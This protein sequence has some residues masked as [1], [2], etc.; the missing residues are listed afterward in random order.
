MIL[1]VRK[2]SASHVFSGVFF[3]GCISNGTQPKT[4]CYLHIPS[5]GAKRKK[6][7]KCIHSSRNFEYAILILNVS[8]LFVGQKRL[9]FQI[10]KLIQIKIK[11]A[12]NFF[13]Q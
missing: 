10:C 13:V 4:G 1:K 9:W 6:Y 7:G 3:L 2:S 8:L 12:F 11:I 5:K